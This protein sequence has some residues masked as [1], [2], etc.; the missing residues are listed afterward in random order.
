M[1]LRAGIPMPAYGKFGSTE[2]DQKAALA[3]KIQEQP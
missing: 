1:P 3:H 2:P